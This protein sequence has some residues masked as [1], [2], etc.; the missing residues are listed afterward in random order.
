MNSSLQ[1]NNA[2]VGKVLLVDT[3]QQIALNIVQGKLDR[4]EVETVNFGRGP[5]EGETFEVIVRNVTIE[6]DQDFM[7]VCIVGNIP[8]LHFAIDGLV[9]LGAIIW[10]H[11]VL[12]SVLF[13]STESSQSLLVEP[14]E[15]MN[16]KGGFISTASTLR[17]SPTRF[18][19][20]TE[21]L[22][23]LRVLIEGRKNHFLS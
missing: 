18:K 15:D 14:I 20:V 3:L 10:A 7:R 23:L 4:A 13:R 6:T 5:L 19:T 2:I 22:K 21:H 9:L 17:G 8:K 16:L 11:S 1:H 12:G